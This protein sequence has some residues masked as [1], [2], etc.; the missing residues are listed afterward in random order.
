MNKK[1]IYSRFFLFL[2]LLLFLLPITVGAQETPEAAYPYRR[3]IEKNKFDRV[4][5]KLFRHL[6]RDTL[7]V[8]L[9]YAA[10]ILFATPSYP[11]FNT[12]S[13]YSHLVT[14]YNIYQ[15]ADPKQTERL[16]RDSYSG[17]LFD[18]R[19]RQ[20]GAMA[21]NG[22]RT[23]GTP[24][25][26]RHFLDYYLLAPDDLR[27]SAV[28][29]RDSVEFHIALRA[30]TQQ[31]L[32]DFITRRPQSHFANMAVHC[33]DSLA[34]TLAD[35]RHST[36]A[37]SQFLAAYPTS[38]LAG[39][40]AD[41]LFL[42]DFRLCRQFDS[43][44]N[45]RAYADRYPSSPYS[46]QAIWLADSI[47]YHRNVDTAQWHSL[48][49]FADMHLHNSWRDTA[50]FSLARFALRHRHIEAADQ[51]V[52]RLMPGTATYAQTAL[53]LHDAYL[54][55]SLRNFHRFYSH[56]PNLM[57]ARARRQ[58]SLAYLL[59]QNYDYRFADS[60][61]RAVAPAHEALLWLQQIL[62]DDI[63]NGRLGAA[64]STAHAYADVFGYNPEYLGLLGTLSTAHTPLTQRLTQ[65]PKS[66]STKVN[67]TQ[68]DEYAPVPSADGQML[69]F[70]G[71]NR[72]FNLGGE[73][74]FY[75]RRHKG[76]WA[77]AELLIDLSHTY[78]N[79]V[80]LSVSPDGNTLFLY[81]TGRLL[82]AQ[83][84]AQE[85]EVWP[86]DLPVASGT[87]TDATLSAD[88]RVLI[89]TAFGPTER[90]VDSSLNIYVSFLDSN[91]HW[92]QPVEVGPDI[93]T[94]FDE[95]SPFLAGD[96]NTLY[97][98][99]E[100]HGSL[101]QMDIYMTTRLDDTYTPWSAPVNLGPV[102]NTTGDDW[103]CQVTADGKNIYFARR[104]TS[105]DIYIAPL[106]IELQPSESQHPIQNR[107]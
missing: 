36:E 46:T 55:T 71:R 89:L 4:E 106:P 30:G 42:L 39:R 50:L 61:I 75:T 59:V 77:E 70:A 25:A 80:P 19:L 57:T 97:F 68:G 64:L 51:A 67:T 58:D 62:K 28:F 29:L 54:H 6:R 17:A 99:S 73:D 87:V 44:Q 90:E 1:Q 34:F 32:D 92:S 95:R 105:L 9:H 10:H 43:E 18:Y 38:Y 72:P 96:M 103:G 8:E 100:G 69:Y 22:A 85:W 93:N 48:L 27:D 86:L 47:E 65:S 107:F 60:C 13:A 14:A 56:Y 91:D 31:M 82:R 83:R 2:T 12:D 52:R 63:D 33:R 21:L 104:T 94:P 20:L 74:I 81:Q 84:Q 23:R 101:G 49:Q 37:Y 40:A 5:Q 102:I 88:G 41:S 78:G 53:L 98:S 35:S 26:F 45:Y 66:I 24:D 79:E 7:S 3:D 16:E 11:H 15:K 76:R